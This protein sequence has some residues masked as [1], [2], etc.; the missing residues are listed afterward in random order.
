MIL[1]RNVGQQM[2]LPSIHLILTELYPIKLPD[3]LE[4]EGC[5]CVLQPSQI[6]IHTFPET[7]LGCRV[8][9]NLKF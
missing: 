5:Y 3:K 1:D 6:D 4:K 2:H 9:D 7:I 8:F